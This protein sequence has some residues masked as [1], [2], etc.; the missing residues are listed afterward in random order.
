MMSHVMGPARTVAT[1][2]KDSYNDAAEGAITFPGGIATGVRSRRFIAHVGSG[3]DVRRGDVL[4]AGGYE[5]H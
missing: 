4:E 3:W 5:H 1:H 2:A